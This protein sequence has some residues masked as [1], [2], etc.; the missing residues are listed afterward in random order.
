LLQHTPFSI[1]PELPAD[2]IN[3]LQEADIGVIRD[4]PSVL[5]LEFRV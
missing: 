4:I 3:A 2:V 5:T 1:I